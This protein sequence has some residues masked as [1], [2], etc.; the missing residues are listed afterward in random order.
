[1][2]LQLLTTVMA[3]N[4]RVVSSGG[5]KFI[6]QHENITGHAPMD[7]HVTLCPLAGLL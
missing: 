4:L 5:L 1:M 3:L 2:K 7:F 6:Q